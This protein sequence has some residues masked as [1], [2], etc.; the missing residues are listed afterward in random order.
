MKI[1]IVEKN[2]DVGTKLEGLIEK[3]VGKLE[4]YFDKNATCKVVCKKEGNV[5]KLELN[6]SAKNAYFRSEVVGD[7]MYSNLD[8]ALPKLEKQII[9]FKG[10]KQT[11]KLP[12][13]VSDLLFLDELPEESLSKITKRKSF[14]LDPITEDDA[15][16]MLEAVDHDF[17][18]FLN[19]ETG[20]VNVLYRRVN[21][22][23][24][25]IEVRK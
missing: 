8:L 21:G 23:Y 5:Y 6:I 3:K 25:L 14:S 16:F 13:I 10:K 24:G 12:E 18:V 7:N 17:Y 2:Y 15:I 22:E 1:D 9:K 11:I 20:R 4:K 19:A